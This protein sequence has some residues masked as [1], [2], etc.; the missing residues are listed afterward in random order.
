MKDV[1][2]GV[3]FVFI[4]LTCLRDTVFLVHLPLDYPYSPYQPK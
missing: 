1:R 3:A 4:Y 2:F